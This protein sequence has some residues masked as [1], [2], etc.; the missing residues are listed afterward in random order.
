M[1]FDGPSTPLIHLLISIGYGGHV[2]TTYKNRPQKEPWYEFARTGFFSLVGQSMKIK[3]GL[4]D[5]TRVPGPKYKSEGFRLEE[6][7]S[8][9]HPYLYFLCFPS[10]ISKLRRFYELI[11]DLTLIL[12]CLCICL[13]ICL[14][15]DHF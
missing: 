15:F 7:V 5:E 3:L 8:F 1:Y 12:S 14:C 6:C 13:L 9:P 10:P 2:I 4:L 11:R